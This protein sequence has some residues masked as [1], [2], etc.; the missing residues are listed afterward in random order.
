MA[1]PQNDWRHAGIG[2]IT[3]AQL[4]SFADKLTEWEKSLSVSAQAFLNVVLARAGAETAEVERF[5]FNIG[6]GASAQ[7]LLA[8]LVASYALS[9]APHGDVW[10]DIGPAWVSAPKKAGRVRRGRRGATEVRQ[11][12]ALGQ[13]VPERAV[14]PLRP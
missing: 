6:F 9:V 4:D 11:R 1:T 13:R 7:S 10:L 12:P 5:Q 3:Q 2:N 14:E 8:P